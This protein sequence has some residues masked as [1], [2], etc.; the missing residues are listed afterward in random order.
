MKN[1]CNHFHSCTFHFDPLI[2]IVEF[3]SIQRDT[4]I[5]NTK[6]TRIRSNGDAIQ[7]TVRQL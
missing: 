1:N 6:K 2:L 5:F 4:V 3:K 7:P